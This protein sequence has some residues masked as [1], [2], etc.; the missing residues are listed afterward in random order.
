MVVHRLHV[1]DVFSNEVAALND[2]SSVF[3]KTG[4][5]SDLE[6]SAIRKNHSTL[7]VMINAQALTDSRGHYLG[8]RCTL[9]DNTERKRAE[10]QAKLATKELE[11]FT[12]SVSHDLRAPLR[13]I[14]GYS[15]ILMED[16]APNL[17]EKGIQVIHTIIR[18]ATRMGQLI[19]DLLNFSHSNRKEIIKSRIEMTALVQGIASELLGNETNR[20]ISLD[21]NDLG[22]SYAD[23]NLL[24]QVWINLLSNALKYSKNKSITKIE[25]TASETPSET[26]YSV[27][28]NGVG[29]NMA[30]YK[31]LF[32]VFSRLHKQTDF[33]GT[34][35][36]LAL[37]KR[38]IDRHNGRIWAE[39][40]ENE[41]ATFYFSIPK[42]GLNNE[43]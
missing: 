8:A 20:E 23:Q 27:K 29:F 21:V 32:D 4:F 22:T 12:Y 16:Y 30:Y 6:S 17:D 2:P 34:G 14:N 19:D 36:G 9:F 11:A 10:D 5:V 37:V 38:I 43:G 7:P 40:Q 41:G 13:S 39:A 25:V 18:N 3:K 35:V 1:T 33:E 42:A 26:I 24:Q 31:K 15:N 28:D